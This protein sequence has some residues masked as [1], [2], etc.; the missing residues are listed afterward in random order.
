MTTKGERLNQV[1]DQVP[2]IEC[3]G[4]CHESCGPVRM[5]SVEHD[6]IQQR[7]G[8]DIPAT[9]LATCP[10]LTMLGRCSVYEDRPMVCRLWG[11]VESLPCPWGC[12]PE[13]TLTAAEGYDL[14]AQAADVDGD[15]AAARRFRS[16]RSGRW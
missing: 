4:L 15:R 14:L 9:G 7:H 8:V 6:A 12:R 13:R 2:A 1:R 5:T 10:A 16:G 3:L 11:V